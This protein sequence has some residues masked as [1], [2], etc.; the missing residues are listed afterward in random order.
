MP[1]QATIYRVL[2]SSPSD[3]EEERNAAHEVV[4]KWNACNDAMQNGIFVEPVRWETH[5]TPQAGDRP[6]EI[7]NKQLVRTCDFMVAFFGSRIGTATGK[8]VSGTVEEIEEFEKEGKP[9]LLYFSS[10][11]VKLKNVDP[12]QLAKVRQYQKQA[13][14]QG[15]T[16]TYRSVAE[17]RELLFAHLTTTVHSFPDYNKQRIQLQ[18]A[19]EKNPFLLEIVTRINLFEKLSERC[20]Q[21]N[22]GLKRAMARYFWEHFFLE[23]VDRDVRGIFFESGSTIAYLSAEFRKKLNAE[24]GKRFRDKF[25]LRTNN[26]LTYLQFI[27]FESLDIA[28][29]PH[30]PPENTYGATF[31]R[32]AHLTKDEPPRE[33]DKI[34]PLRANAVPIVLDM[35]T[36]LVPY[37]M[38]SLLLGTASGLE[39]RE[40]SPFPGPHVG[41]YHNKLFKRAMLKSPHPLILF[42]DAGKISPLSD[43]GAFVFNK[44]HP[45][46]DDAAMWKELCA[47]IPLAFC[48]GASDDTTLGEVAKLFERIGFCDHGSCKAVDDYKVALFQ[49]EA[50]GDRLGKR[51][52]VR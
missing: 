50:F 45:V 49:N 2:I 9:V 19:I 16:G 35:A 10:A 5:A 18:K 34:V 29:V 40:D 22:P 11:P 44:C 28:L 12:K 31:G 37:E 13:Q 36:E 43:E 4:D 23:I 6:Q 42:L 15:L 8:A 32:I 38:P 20:T 39:L 33:G 48:L 26:I 3:V 47:K 41:S 27:L 14:K 51:V 24:D 30:G 25:V 52:D 21:M 7:L 1:F 46:C 17:F